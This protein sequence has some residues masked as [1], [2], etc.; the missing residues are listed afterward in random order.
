MPN[1]IQA[2]QT[3]TTERARS[4][5][6]LR[7]RY[8][9][10]DAQGIVYHGAFFTFFE[11]ARLDLLVALL[12][13]DV[14]ATRFWS[15]LAIASAQCE[16]RAPVRYPEVV[17]IT[18]DVSKIGK[19]SFEVRYEVLNDECVLVAHG[20]TVQVHVD[21]QGR[22]RALDRPKRLRLGSA[23]RPGHDERESA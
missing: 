3:A 11:V 9:D 17:I 19:T 5:T 23:P 15:R 1:D 13:S 8:A 14:A 22:P 12:G 4:T 2:R 10:T 18:A 7:V 20:T 6:R 16:Y 21:A